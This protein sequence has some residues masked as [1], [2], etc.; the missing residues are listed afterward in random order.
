MSRKFTPSRLFSR[1]ARTLVYSWPKKNPRLADGM[2]RNWKQSE[3]QVCNFAEQLNLHVRFMTLAVQ[4]QSLCL[5]WSDQ[6]MHFLSW[7]ICDIY[8]IESIGGRAVHWWC[9]VTT[10]VGKGTVAMWDNLN[11]CVASKAAVH[12]S[13]TGKISIRLTASV[14]NQTT[15]AL[16]TIRVATLFIMTRFPPIFRAWKKPLIRNFRVSENNILGKLTKNFGRKSAGITICWCTSLTTCLCSHLRTL[17][18]EV[19]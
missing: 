8:G 17:V 1:V 3:L 2:L 7:Q 6:I 13:H 19:F 18:P 12:V 16:A 10:R 9:P 5:A 15:R 4:H 11:F 14:C